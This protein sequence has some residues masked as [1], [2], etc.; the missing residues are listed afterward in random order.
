MVDGNL[1]YLNP[2]DFK[3]KARGFSKDPDAIIASAEKWSE[4]SV[5]FAA[6][7]LALCIIGRMGGLI[8]GI[9]RFGLGGV[10]ISDIPSGIGAILMAVAGFLALSTL[11]LV[12]IYASKS[13]K[14][15]IPIIVTDIFTIIV[16][17]AG[18]FLMH[19]F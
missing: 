18:Y 16:L 6:A 8:S 11:V 5:I 15:I 2:K 4:K 3:K 17:V 14:K 13:K 7:G 19:I 10:I 1:A 9:G 12:L